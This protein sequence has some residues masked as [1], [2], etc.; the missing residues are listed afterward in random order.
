MGQYAVLQAVVAE[1]VVVLEPVRTVRVMMLMRR[2][3]LIL[4][5]VGL[6]Q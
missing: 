1:A 3:L 4:R 5:S 2:L 6:L